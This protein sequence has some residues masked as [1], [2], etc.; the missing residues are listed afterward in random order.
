MKS[1]LARETDGTIQLTITIPAENVAKV[2]TE[3]VEHMAKDANVAGFRKGKAPKNLVE[4]KLNPEQIREEILKKLLP[5]FY[6]EALKEHSITPILSPRIHIQ[7]AEDPTNASGQVDWIFVAATC[8]LPVIDLGDYK[9]KI[10]TLTAK[11]KIAIPGK[12]APKPI[13]FDEIAQVILNTVSIQV[14]HILKEGEVDRM[15]SQL[16]D[17]VKRLGMTLDQYLASTNKNPQ[18]LR[19]EYEQKVENDIKLEFALQKIAE[20]EKLTVEEKEIDEAIAK[21]KD[22]KEKEHLSSNRYLLANILR[23]QKTLDFLKS[24]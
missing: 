13:S 22:E 20:T 6:I 5:E 7:K 9:T 24:L 16:L 19:I 17:D 11:Q 21:A 15:L 4:E 14:P 10:Q 23:Q 2:R 18:S 1:I 12:E 8:E 3:V